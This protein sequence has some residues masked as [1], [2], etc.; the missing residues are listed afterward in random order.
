[1]FVFV[2]NPS[3]C[4]IKE[5]NKIELYIYVSVTAKNVLFKL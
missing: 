2:G 1:M 4:L 5:R 3:S